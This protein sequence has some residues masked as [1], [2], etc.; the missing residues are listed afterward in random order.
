MSVK[1]FTAPGTWAM[2]NKLLAVSYCDFFFLPPIQV[3]FGSGIFSDY[4]DFLRIVPGQA[5][6]SGLPRR[7]PGKGPQETGSQRHMEPPPR[8]LRWKLFWGWQQPSQRTCLPSN[9]HPQR[10]GRAT[11][12]FCPC[13][14]SSV[15]AGSHLSF[16][17]AVT[18]FVSLHL[19]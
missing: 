11:P 14:C 18:S 9:P 17:H 3:D 6:G 15:K 1:C 5:G 2:S 7:R 12:P 8:A 19:L 4:L 13:L 16:Q 10:Q